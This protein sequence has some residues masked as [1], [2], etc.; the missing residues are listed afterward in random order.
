[1]NRLYP[2]KRLEIQYEAFRR[3][4]N[5]R[6]VVVGGYAHA[7]HAEKYFRRLHPPPNV[8]FRGEIDERELIRLYAQCRG[9]VCTAIDEDFG[10]TPVEAMASGK[11]V[12]A[13]NEG[14]YRETIREGRTGF[15]L[16]PDAEAFAAKIRSLGD[17]LLRSMKDDCLDRAR[18]FD[19]S[20]FVEKMRG[21]I[22]GA[23]SQSAGPVH[24]EVADTVKG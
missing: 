15:L 8:E 18:A 4:P 16:P 5:E 14:G 12:L 9:L 13:T 23:P 2:E 10:L 21:L 11:C 20:I 7:D 22:E 6:L 1:V 3:L 17:D 19:E 24:P